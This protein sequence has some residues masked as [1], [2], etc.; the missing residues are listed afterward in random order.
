MGTVD[1]PMTETILA[2]GRA[3]WFELGIIEGSL[4]VQPEGYLLQNQV[5]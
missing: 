4:Q 3:E 1:R 5:L 2:L